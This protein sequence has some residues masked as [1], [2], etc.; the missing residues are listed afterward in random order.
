MTIPELTAAQT[1]E[2]ER[3]LATLRS[4]AVEIIPVDGLRAK[5]AES[6]AAGRPL[7]VKLG[8]DPTAPDIHLGHTV[9]INKLKQFQD[10]GH[11]VQ[12]VIGDFTGRIGDP[13]GRSTARKQLTEE[14]VQQNA[15]TYVQQYG[16][17]LD[18][19]RTELHFNSR[20]LAPLNFADVVRLT[21]TYTLARMLEREDFQQRWQNNL[22]ISLHEFFYPLM[23]G[24]DSVALQTDIEIGGTDQTFNLLV[25]RHLQREY[26]QPEQ[27]VMTFPL[28]EGLDGVQKMSKSLGN[29]IGIS[30]PAGEMYGKLMSIPDQLMLKYYQLVTG[31]AADQLQ[32]LRSGLADASLHPRDVKM[33]LAHRLVARYH[34]LAAADEAEARFRAVFQERS[35]PEEMPVVEWAGQVPAGVVDLLE[36]TGL[37]STRSEA[38]RLIEQGAVRVNEQRVSDQFQLIDL[39]E[40]TVLQVG[41]RKFV[42]VVA[43]R[44]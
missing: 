40:Q 6:I 3:Q 38:R 24:Y 20:W 5:L 33:Q 34:S 1:D 16:K 14:Q 27:V 30:E 43:V 18:I 23:Q 32:Q 2:L 10:C 36:G 15:R 4:A 17:I 28:L 19:E 37:V 35:L 39:R 11:L 29:Y 41:R 13:S 7:R 44:R 8:L 12:L 21:A 31:I 22:P 25:G 9:V 42:R 26:G